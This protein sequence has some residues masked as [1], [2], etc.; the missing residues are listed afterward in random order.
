MADYDITAPDGR[1]F[2][3]TAP[4]GAPQDQVLAYAQAQFSKMPTKEKT[5]A[6]SAVTAAAPWVDALAKGGPG[7]VIGLGAKKL[8]EGMDKAAEGAGGL[9]TD[10]AAAFGASPEVAAG[11]GAATNAALQVLPGAG[12]GATMKAPFEWLGK[13]LMQSALKPSS[14]N[15][16]NKNA[17]KAIQT[18]LDEGISA[19]P[20]GAAKLRTEIDKLKSQVGEMIATSPADVDKAWAASEL[21]KTLNKFRNQVNPGADEKAILASWDEFNKLVGAKI[22]V[23]DAQ[24][25][26]EGTQQ[27]LRDKYGRTTV[28]PAGEA[29]EKSMARG[30]RLGIEDAV[31]GVGELNARNSSL[32]NVLKQLEPR[33]GQVAN[34]DMAGIAPVANSPEAAGLML[35]DR[36]PWVKSLLAQI[37]YSN[38]QRIPAALGGVGTALPDANRQ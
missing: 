23:Q 18:M 25:L 37:L 4:D 7:G 24:K 32:I 27:M 3:V 10:S 26:K 28:T 21:Y 29:A 22:P 16:A 30:L 12:V 31:P 5:M 36:N 35:A 6:Q 38:K 2:T 9:V 17:A 8:M 33:L 19:T 15:I 14:E 34:R 1:K 11:A 13:R 20:A